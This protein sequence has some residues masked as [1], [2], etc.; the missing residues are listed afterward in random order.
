MWC[1]SQHD[2]FAEH[3]ITFAVV[4]GIFS[5]SFCAIFWFNQRGVLPGLCF[6]NKLISHDEA[7]HCDFA[8][9]LSNCLL[10][11]PCS[12]HVREIVNSAIQIKECFICEAHLFNLM[13]M[14]ATLVSLYIRF[15]ADC[16]LHKL[17]QPTIVYNV[18]NP[19][20][21]MDTISLQGKTKFFEK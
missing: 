12:I 14:N 10:K 18:T 13:G 4:E 15:C 9:V 21:W 17:K 20:P 19:F 8:C 1:N 7:L 11:P 5:S 2:S 6:A 16:L 3:L